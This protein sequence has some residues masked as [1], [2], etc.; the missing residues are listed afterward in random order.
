L[1]GLQFYMFSKCVVLYF[2]LFHILD[3]KINGMH[4]SSAQISVVMGYYVKNVFGIEKEK[5]QNYPT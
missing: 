2:D 3:I 1:L 5:L 4:L